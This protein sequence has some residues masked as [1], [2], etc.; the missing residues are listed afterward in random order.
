MSPPADRTKPPS[1][2]IAHGATPPRPHAAFIALRWLAKLSSLAVGAT[3]P[4]ILLASREQP[5]GREWLGVAFFPLG[6][7]FGLLLGLW[8][9]LLGAAIAL[10]SL[11][12][13]YFM[14]IVVG[15][16]VP[17]G[18]YFAILSSPALLLLI[19]GLLSRRTRRA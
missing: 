1:A 4:L 10:S 9:E 18:P 13:F 8:R 16:T 7:A 17:K 5:T 14:F 2:A 6:V 12:T 11:A 19:S 15:Q 3:L